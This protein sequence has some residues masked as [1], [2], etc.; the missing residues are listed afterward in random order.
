EDVE[1][2]FAITAHSRLSRR[3]IAGILRS[4]RR[5]SAR[6]KSTEIVVTPGEILANDEV[7]VAIEAAS[8]DA[9]TKVRTAIAWLERAR[10]LQRDE[11]HVRV[12]PGSLRVDTLEAAKARLARAHLS[13]EQHRKYVDLLH[14][15]INA[16]DDKGISTDELMLQVGVSPEQCVRMLQ[17][18]EALGILSNDIALTVLLRK[19][20]KDA[21][22]DRLARLIRLETALLH[23]LPELAPDAAAEGWQVMDLRAL[24][25][26]AKEATGIDCLPD[27]V[28]RLM[29]SLAR[30]FGDGHSVQRALFDVRVVRREVLRVRLLR[31][32]SNICEI[33]ARRRSVATVLLQTLLARLDAQLQ[34]VDLRVACMLGELGNELR[35]DTEVGPGLKDELRAIEAGLL[36]LHDNGVLI[37]D[38]GKSV[39]R[40]AMTL[41]LD[42]AEKQRRFSASDFAPLED[43]YEQKNFQVHVIQEYARLALAKLSDA[44]AFVIAY[45]GLSRMAF[46]RRYFAGRREV[47]ERATTAESWRRIVE[48]LRHPLQ[49]AIVTASV[50]GNRLIL[51]GPGSGKTRVIVHRVAYLVRVLREPAR[52]IIVLAFNR[53]AAL[54]IRQRLRALIGKDAAGV[55]VLTY[56]ALALRLTGSSVAGLAR[57]DNEIDFG[58]ILDSALALLEGA[59][60]G[61]SPGDRDELRER[62]LTG[63][64]HILV[65]EYQ[66]IDERQYRLISALAG[67]RLRDRDTKLTLLAVGDDDQNI[68]AFR[69]TSNEFITRFQSDYEAATDYLVE[70]YRSSANIVAAA[71]QI[72][73]GN[74]GRLKAEHPIRI[75][76]TRREAPAGGR[77]QRLDTIAHGRVCVLGVPGNFIGQAEAVMAEL[78]RIKALD[79]GAAWSD[80]AVLA[81]NRASLEPIRAWCELEGIDWCSPDGEQGQPRL[82][83]TREGCA[84]LDMLAAKPR[85]TLPATALARWFV[86]RFRGGREDNPWQGLLRQFIDE[87]QE[88]WPEGKIPTTIIVDA[89]YEF[90]YEARRSE[91][92]RVLVSTVHAAKGRELRH[93]AILDSGE[94]KRAA[95]DE[96]R[97]YYVGMTRAR[98][99]L[100]LCERSTHPN[101]YSR[102][103]KGDEIMRMPVP[104]RPL[105]RAELAR[106]HLVLGQADVVLGY[107]GGFAANHPVQRALSRLAYGDALDLIVNGDRRELRTLQGI[108]VGR[109]ARRSKLPTGRVVRVSVES[110]VRRTRMRTEPE[111][112][113]RLRVEEWWVILPRIVIEPESDSA[114]HAEITT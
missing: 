65:D 12:F 16:A 83:Q 11:N 55:A 58:A 59:D 7:E 107:G 23:A 20:V 15:L 80:F 4:L 74:R 84:L 42:P 95:D 81:R 96:R 85:R 35:N 47:L 53:M 49:E 105:R 19:G 113:D 5:Y 9:D 26:Q 36:Y 25:Q 14:A 43:H 17:Q 88:I 101:P 28:S 70:N 60:S 8:P 1:A 89:L 77:W 63:Y 86:L 99:N 76:H 104:A 103:L 69:A 56:H 108:V 62:L 13:A 22:S 110:I 82:T 67:R 87:L 71:N 73:A 52:S 40:A 64:R 48:D 33:A 94:W 51:A 66:D 31:T 44:L 114:V 27:Q 50:D 91:R 92:G 54:E 79:T 112:R 29:R 97:L 100:I 37:I 102:G 57:Q 61:E 21:S 6:T 3:D 45:F 30:P 41:R 98:E 32:W 109:L 39:F 38:R 75:N 106:R 34:G 90:G 111:H 18:L 78:A 68:Y 93:V 24:C 2:Q 72:I 46:I 10:F